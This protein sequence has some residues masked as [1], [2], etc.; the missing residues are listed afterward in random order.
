MDRRCNSAVL[1]NWGLICT[2]SLRLGRFARKAKEVPFI[3]AGVTCIATRQR[4]DGTR[5]LQ[6][7]VSS[8]GVC[9]GYLLFTKPR[10]NKQI[11]AIRGGALCDAM[12][13]WY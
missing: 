12:G 1:R 5:W 6:K 8:L 2:T 3:F 13:S 7:Q 11:S 4:R 10:R 9:E